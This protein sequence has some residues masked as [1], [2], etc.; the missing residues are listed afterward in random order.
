L[1]S[2]S[3]LRQFDPILPGSK[4]G[5]ATKSITEGKTLFTSQSQFAATSSLIATP[6][7]T[8]SYEGAGG[9]HFSPLPKTSKHRTFLVVCTTPIQHGNGFAL[10]HKGAN[11]RRFKFIKGFDSQL[12]AEKEASAFGCNVGGCIWI[13]NHGKQD[14]FARVRITDEGQS[15]FPLPVAKTEVLVRIPLE[16]AAILSDGRQWLSL[17]RF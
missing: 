3:H 12:D 16:L 14:L 6:T 2:I 8:A 7:A 1:G 17:V 15:G 11:D 4:N 5:N 9:Y 10:Y 13:N